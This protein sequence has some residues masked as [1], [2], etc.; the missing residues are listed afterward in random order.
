[1][2]ANISSCCCALFGEGGGIK[3]LREHA[4][5]LKLNRKPVYFIVMNVWGK[6]SFFFI[7]DEASFF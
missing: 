3:V 1:M 7:R 6:W 4:T 2:K 5:S